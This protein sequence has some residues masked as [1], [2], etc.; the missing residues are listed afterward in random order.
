MTSQ[1]I[2]RD[3]ARGAG[4][5][6]FFTAVVCFRG[7]QCERLVSNGLCIECSRIN[8]ADDRARNFERERQR[9]K[10]YLAGVDPEKA[11]AMARARY[12]K[13]KHKKTKKK[14]PETFKRWRLANLDAVKL[15]LADYKK[16]NKPRMR[17]YERN[18]RA[19]KSLSI[20]KHSPAEIWQLYD[21]QG[22]GCAACSI[23]VSFKSKHV[24][25]IQPL[26]AGGSN[27]IT[28]LQILCAPCNLS[29][30]AKDPIAWAQQMG[31]LI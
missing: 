13:N 31:R 15:A 21:K 6:R 25:H 30:G 24:D 16:N 22:G 3:E 14:N 19:R 18:R 7:H 5:K 12:A 23:A 2:S 20:G 1:T 27:D 4:L 29:K 28:N 9:K 8:K 11:R 26:C 10:R 17:T